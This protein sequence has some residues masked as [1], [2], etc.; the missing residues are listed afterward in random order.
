VERTGFELSAPFLVCLT[1]ASCSVFASV[2]CF[3]S[4]AQRQYAFSL[5]AKSK[6]KDE[7]KVAAGTVDF[8]A[9]IRHRDSP[10]ANMR[11]W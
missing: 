6:E 10:N 3:G 1:T 8:A 11:S 5:E 2:C 9:V 7:G 4:L